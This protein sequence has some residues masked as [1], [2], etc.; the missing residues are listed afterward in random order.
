MKDTQ[1][2]P[3]CGAVNPARRPVCRQCGRF[4]HQE[5]QAGFESATPTS[6]APE[7]ANAFA[8]P[9]PQPSALTRQRFLERPQVK[10]VRPSNRRKFLVG[11]LGSAAILGLGSPALFQLEQNLQVTFEG[12]SFPYDSSKHG[13]VTCYSSDLN[14]IGLG[15]DNGD[16]S[17]WDYQQQR[18]S[19]LP[20]AD[21]VV[22]LCAWSADNN[23]ILCQTMTADG[24]A[25]LDMWDVQARQKIRDYSNPDYV[26][27]GDNFHTYNKISWSP[28]GSQIA[29]HLKNS[30][31][32]LDSAHLAP[33]FTLQ[34]SANGAI[35]DWSPDGRKLALLVGNDSTGDWSVQI[36]NLQTREMDQ[37]GF[38]HGNKDG[39]VC[40]LAWSPDGR[41]IAALAYKQLQIIR[42]SERNSNYTL[43]E[44]NDYGKLA[45]SPDGRHLAVAVNLEVGDSGLPAVRN[46]FN[47][48]DIIEQAKVREL[49]IGNLI[50]SFVPDAIAWSKDGRRITAISSFYQQDNWNWP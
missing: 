42:A 25:S 11:L 49:N 3:A 50:V 38:F 29:L 7:P 35:F 24:P 39:E 19:T 12:K 21:S 6:P 41:N 40:A 22:G 8:G 17:I 2:C 23:F 37:E 5:P 13:I 27:S 34:V 10:I 46:S 30:F 36:W 14:Y 18:M 43:D 20:G 44:P 47:V 45:W 4:L 9:P 15:Q 48:W 33:L 16:L 26:L 1:S 28:D 31:A 32:I